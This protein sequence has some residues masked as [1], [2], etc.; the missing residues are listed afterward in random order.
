[1]TNN[2]RNILMSEYNYSLPQSKIRKCPLSMRESAKLLIYNNGEIT[3]TRFSSFF[4]IIPKDS[5][6]MLNATKVINARLFFRKDSGAKIEILCLSPVDPPAYD[7]IFK[8][9]GGTC[10]WE[11]YVGNLSKWKEG[12]LVNRTV[13]KGNHI[14]LTVRLLETKGDVHHIE[15]KWNNE[16]YNFGHVLAIFGVMP[17]PPYLNRKADATDLDYYQTTYCAIP[18]SVASPTAGL[19]FNRS[20]ILQLDTRNILHGYLVLHVGAGTF[21][22]VTSDTIGGHEMHG[23]RFYIRDACIRIFTYCLGS[24]IA[25]GTTTARTIESL[26]YLGVIISRK[27][28]ITPA[29]LIV[30]QWMAYDPANNELSV[31]DSLNAVL[32]YME[33]HKMKEITAVT[34][35]LIVPGYKFKIV[36]GM[37]T[38]FHQPQSTLLLM[39]DAFVE[40]NW[41]QIY[42]YALNHDFRFLSYGDGSLLLSNSFK[43]SKDTEALSRAW[44]HKS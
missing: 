4:D 43:P 38:N 17:I 18:G 16:N 24:V 28:D 9:Y 2:P 29:E 19:H 33:T 35:I 21:K 8:N 31:K 44:K 41:K 36:S 13:I 1:M 34:Y 23:E 15:F 25:V 12:P 11:C 42:D 39:V 30:D 27:P 14:E 22:P 6:I 3:E 37:F 5:L 7:A 40:G 26:Y 10:V 32:G 20:T